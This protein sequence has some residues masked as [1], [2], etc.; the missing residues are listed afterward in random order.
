M[1]F[2]ICLWIKLIS[3]NKKIIRIKYRNLFA[4]IDT[5][6]LDHTKYA[7]ACTHAGEFGKRNRKITEKKTTT[8]TQLSIKS[9]NLSWAW[10]SEY[11]SGILLIVCEYPRKKKNT[12]DQSLHY[13]VCYEIVFSI[14]IYFFLVLLNN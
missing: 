8:W 4:T 7:L 2:R 12:L 9:I 5:Q 13:I 1:A 14:L 3:L 10:T 6:T 11:T